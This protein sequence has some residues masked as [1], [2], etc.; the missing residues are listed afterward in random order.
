MTTVVVI[1]S[2]FEGSALTEILAKQADVD[3][4]ILADKNLDRAKNLSQQ[5]GNKSEAQFVDISDHDSVVNLLKGGDLVVNT[6]G[7]FFIHG[8]KVIRAAIE[9]RKDYVDIADDYDVTTELLSLDSEV[10]SAGITALINMGSSPGLLNVFAR[11]GADKLDTVEEIHTAWATHYD[12][13]GGPSAGSHAFHMLDGDVPQYIDGQWV[14]VPAGSGVE[15]INFPIRQI[16]CF[17]VGHAEPITLPRYIKG[18]RTVTNKGVIIPEWI[19]YDILKMMELGL[20]GTNP[21]K[22]RG[23]N[24]VIPHE[25]AMRLQAIYFQERD[26]GKAEGG[27]KTTV[28]G[29]RN[30]DEVTYIYD[31]PPEMAREKTAKTTAHS[32]VTGILMVIRGLHKIRGVS[33]PE[34]LDADKFL[35][36]ITNLGISYCETEVLSRKFGNNSH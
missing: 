28:K 9:A 6:I 15:K 34:R 22:I 21:I 29:T 36:I 7:P 26:L 19:S 20:R 1:G 12:G 13:G 24:Y 23:E 30:G 8:T 5:I 18:V 10:K 31:L 14:K 35:G 17:Y 3:K 32:A 33:P 16:E 2:G 25:V 11:Y 4:L 27:F